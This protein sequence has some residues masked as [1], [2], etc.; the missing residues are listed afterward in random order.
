M[1]GNLEEE[2][3][4]IFGE[5]RYRWDGIFCIHTQ[6]DE[7]NISNICGFIFVHLN[8][9]CLFLPFF[10]FPFLVYILGHLFFVII[11]SIGL[12]EHCH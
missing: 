6:M 4:K 12:D 11:L 3:R 10:T 2:S 1:V 5:V 7:L 8:I 9:P